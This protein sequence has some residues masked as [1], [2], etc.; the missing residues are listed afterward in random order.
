MRVL[1]GLPDQ[2]A[3]MW[4]ELEGRGQ[5]AKHLMIGEYSL[6]LLRASSDFSDRCSCINATRHVS[7]DMKI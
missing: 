1:N 2:V 3:E 7:I 6:T 4:N 5:P